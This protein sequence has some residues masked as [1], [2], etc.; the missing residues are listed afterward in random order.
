VCHDDDDDDDDDGDAEEYND[1]YV[2]VRARA[3]LLLLYV[4]G[5]CVCHV[6]HIHPILQTTPSIVLV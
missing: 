2:C 5:V 4:E 3:C 6:R 1:L